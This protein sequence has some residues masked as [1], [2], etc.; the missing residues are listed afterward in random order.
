V[1]VWA[2]FWTPAGVAVCGGFIVLAVTRWDV[3]RTAARTTSSGARSGPSARVTDRSGG[4]VA[5][6]RASWVDEVLV[7]RRGS[8]FCTTQILPVA[9]ARGIVEIAVAAC[10]GD[11]L[12]GPFLASHAILRRTPR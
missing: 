10:S 3:D 8:F 7:L 4:A 1:S 6:W 2:W 11:D 12:A 5:R 9:S